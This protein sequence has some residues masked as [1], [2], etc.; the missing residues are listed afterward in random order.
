MTKAQA[1]DYISRWQAVAEFERDLLIERTHAGLVR[2]KAQ[3]KKLGRPS[4]LTPDQQETV[5]NK[6][7]QGASLGKLA[8]EYGVSRSAIQRAERQSV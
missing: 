1:T 3:G 2:A 6:R 4:S 5:R 7:S 8:K